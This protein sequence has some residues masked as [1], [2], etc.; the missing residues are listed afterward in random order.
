MT[1]LYGS[2][3]T[4]A[5]NRT[6]QG[7]VTLTLNRPDT[8][9]AFSDAMVEELIDFFHALGKDRA[10]RVLTITGAGPAFS[11]GGDIDM[12]ES[13]HDDVDQSIHSSRR[14]AA[15]MRAMHD[16]E[17]PIV[18]LVNGDML[19]GGF[20]LALLA[21]VVLMADSAR[22][23]IGA[24]SNINVLSGPE[25]W[26]LPLFASPMKAR[27]HLLR[28][29]FIDAAAA[30]QM[31]LVSK[32]VPAD[33]LANEGAALAA[34]IIKQDAMTMAWTKRTAN[35]MIEQSRPLLDL[36]VALEGFMFGRAPARQGLDKMRK[37]LEGG[38]DKD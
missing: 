34:D 23:L 36:Y 27:Y 10:A 28:A 5:V 12:L 15:A 32:V 4:L 7:H 6:D 33:A 24:Q 25:T 22:I 1:A 20:A 16:C 29:G 14:F 2:F 31:G 30:D 9:N 3:D 26:L 38:H 35:H 11:V 37:T 13:F 17:I 21:D 8:L 18:A 19:G